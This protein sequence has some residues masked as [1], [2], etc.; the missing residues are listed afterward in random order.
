MPAAVIASSAGVLDVNRQYAGRNL[1]A[2]CL[3]GE[4]THQAHCVEAICLCHPDEVDAC[5]F[6]ICRLLHGFEEASAVIEG[7][8]QLHAELPCR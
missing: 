7:R 8:G 2:V 1:D 3:A 6:E 5:A 4:A